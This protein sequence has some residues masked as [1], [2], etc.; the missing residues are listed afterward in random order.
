MLYDM[1]LCADY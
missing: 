1:T